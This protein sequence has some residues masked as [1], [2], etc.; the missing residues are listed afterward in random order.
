MQ[1]HIITLLCAVGLAISGQ[2][3]A[4]AL[5]VR[6]DAPRRYV[7]KPGDT[8]WGISGKYLYSPWQWNR[9][10][11]A[12]RN[13]VRNPHMIYPGQ[14]LVLRYINGR[15]V[16]GF[17]KAVSYREGGI[18]VVKLAPRVR[19]MSA[20]YGIQT[21]NVNFY[22]MF[23]QHPQVIPQEQTQN[24]PRLIDGPDSRILY[25][26]GDRVYA[27][28]ITEPGRY[29]VYRAVKDIT[30]PDT[31]KY[32]GQ[33]VVFGGIVS[34]LPHTNSAL[35]ARSEK[36]ARSLPSN[37]YYT[38]LHP[39]V[40]V[41]TQT[42]QPMV[43]EEAVSE[44]RKG[45]FLLKITDE[46]DNFQIMPHA[47]SRHIDAKVVSIFNGIGEAGQFQTITLNKGEADGLDK[48]TVLSLYKRSR[49]T[50]VELEN[51]RKGSRSVVKYVSIP[52]EEAGLAMI[53]R[54]G[55]NLSSA[56][57]LESL[58]S[59]NIGDTASEPGQD[60]DNMADDTPHAPNAPQ[61]PHDTEL[62]EYN[63]NSNINP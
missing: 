57:I 60:L 36:D 54:T 5:K 23:M 17:D 45:D 11:G 22:R 58:T 62:N 61:E 10:W 38:R 50:K 19:E 28:G 63:I 56:I 35:D 8:L 55:P 51:G 6:P 31:K 34:T 14:V 7:V 32:L 39:L 44:V 15:P 40:K 16:L 33:E 48:G 9:L 21:I 43:I 30:D 41:P 12:N 53:Y 26:K 27:Y 42:A 3:S 13:A 52:A 46:A 24:A 25:S 49:Q 2:A 47:P 4:A 20:G 18:P 37:E 1:K 59:I 29:L